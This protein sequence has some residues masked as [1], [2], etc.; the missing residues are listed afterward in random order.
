VGSRIN[1]H[2]ESLF[3]AFENNCVNLNT[4]RPIQLS[5]SSGTVVSG[6]IKLMRVFA[7]FCRKETSNDSGVV[8]HAH[9]PWSH[10]EDYSLCA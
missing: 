7:S 4:D 6:N 10:A 9:V 5:C 3:L 2:L 8:H 1:A